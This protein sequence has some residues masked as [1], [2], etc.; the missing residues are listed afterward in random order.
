MSCLLNTPV[1]IPGWSAG[2]RVDGDHAFYGSFDAQDGT[3]TF[4]RPG[5]VTF[6]VY[7]NGRQESVTM[8]AERQD[9]VSA[10]SAPELTIPLVLE[11][12]A[13]P[14]QLAETP[15]ADIPAGDGDQAPADDEAADPPQETPAKSK[16]G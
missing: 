14:V 5:S 4:S 1:K 10:T 8:T 16:K 3:F 12:P 7:A 9:V 6:M 2:A 15:P 11:P 13:D